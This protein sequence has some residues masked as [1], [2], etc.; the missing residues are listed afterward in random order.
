MKLKEL[1]KVLYHYTEIQ[2]YN[3]NSEYIGLFLP[4]HIEESL[5]DKKVI[6]ISINNNECLEIL[7]EN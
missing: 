5:F 2:L 1:L 7:I 4:S 6:E 3:T